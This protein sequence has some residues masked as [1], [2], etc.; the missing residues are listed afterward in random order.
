MNSDNPDYVGVAPQS[1]AG[2]TMKA[3]QMYSPYGYRGKIGLIVPSTNT[4]AEPEFNLLAPK[5]VSI[6]SARIMLL[7]KATEE[8]YLCMRDDTARAAAELAT[9]EVD[10][11]MWGCT[12]GS[13]IVPRTTLEGIIVDQ[14]QVPA[15]STMSAVLDALRL[16]KAK[17]IALGTPYVDFVNQAEVELLEKEGFK[18]ASCYGLQ[19]GETQEERRGIGR[20]PPESLHRLVRYIDRPDV[21]VIFLSCTN[22][23]TVTMIEALEQE[24]GKPVIT[25]NIASIW[26]SFR[27]IG[28]NDRFEGYGTLLRDF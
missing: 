13:V 10:M 4:V 14:T 12:S 5:G 26:R 15:I 3:V 24:V 8:S 28:I 11:V 25:S 7:G 1:V 9:A 18:V 21:D 23:A 16:L 17:T 22:L 20:V 6:H 2:E 19:L 27:H